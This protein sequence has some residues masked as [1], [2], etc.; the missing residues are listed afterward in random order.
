MGAGFP[1]KAGVLVVSDA[2]ASDFRRGKDTD[3][4][5]KILEKELWKRGYEVVRVIV[6]NNRSEI[7]KNLRK[8]LRDP[9]VRLIVVT[10]GTGISE[11]DITIEAVEPLYSK[12]LPGVGEALRRIGF[13]KVGFPALLSRTSAGIANGKPIFCLPGSPGAVRTAA[14][15]LLSNLDHIFEEL[16]KQSSPEDTWAGRTA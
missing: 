10:G 9:E 11:R 15:F 16:S 12:P 5:G 6:P 8:F 1:A 13:E 4:S 7:R 2:R 14:R 3:V